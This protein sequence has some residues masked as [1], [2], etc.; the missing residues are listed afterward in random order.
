MTY[1]ETPKI[2]ICQYGTDGFG[3]QFEGMLRMLSSS[4]NGK[5]NY[6][7]H[8]RKSYTFQHSNFELDRLTNYLQ[9]GLNILSGGNNGDESEKN[10]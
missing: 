4:L 7:Y 6:M 1:N 3:H 9:F 5:T 8:F 2:K 10:S